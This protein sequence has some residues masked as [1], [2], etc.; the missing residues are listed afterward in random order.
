LSD[1]IGRLFQT[2][3]QLRNNPIALLQPPQ[4]LVCRW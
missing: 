1:H 4:R 3:S 2:D